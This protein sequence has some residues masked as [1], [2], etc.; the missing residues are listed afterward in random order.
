MFGY[1]SDRQREAQDWFDERDDPTTTPP[2][3]V[4]KA[5][6]EGDGLPYTAESFR[7]IDAEWDEGRPQHGELRS[8]DHT[9]LY[10]THARLSLIPQDEVPDEC[11]ACQHREGIYEY[12]AYHNIAGSTTVTCD[13]CG[14]TL[15]AVSW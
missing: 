10:K 1:D 5:F 11:P 9:N 8:D 12:D 6:E 13:R 15:V 14:E 3:W 7:V 4:V 2:A